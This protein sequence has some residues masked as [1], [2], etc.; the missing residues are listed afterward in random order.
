MKT[1]IALLLWA[2]AAFAS[3]EH[4]GTP[5]T[6]TGAASVDAAIEKLAAGGA[7]DFLIEGKVAKVC[8]AKGCWLGLEVRPA[9]FT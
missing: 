1:A 4:Y 6:L 7:A 2:A 3:A 9:R 8:K 5:I